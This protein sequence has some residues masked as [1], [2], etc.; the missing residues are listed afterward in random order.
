M[1]SHYCLDP[2]DLDFSGQLHVT[3]EGAYPNIKLLSATDIHKSNILS[4]L[5]I[6]Q[7]RDIKREIAVYFRFDQLRRP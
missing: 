7:R 5:Y 4:D 6:E 3:F 1:H 2:N